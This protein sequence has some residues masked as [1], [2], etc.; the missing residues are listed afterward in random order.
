[1]ALLLSVATGAAM[2]LGMP[3]G[4]LLGAANAFVVGAF[5]GLLELAVLSARQ[6]VWKDLWSVAGRYFWDVITIGFI[7]WVPLQILELGMQANP[8]GSVIA[9]AVFLLLFILL[10]PVSRT[11]LS[12]TNRGLAQDPQRTATNLSWKT[13][14]SGF[15]RLPSSSRPWACPFFFPSPAK[16]DGYPGWIF[17]SSSGCP[18]SS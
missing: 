8:Y 9:S 1:M 16:A 7:V 13:G 2:S 11:D 3:G 17:C 18:L 6:M 4:L 10:N 12:G 5:L 15:C 14:L